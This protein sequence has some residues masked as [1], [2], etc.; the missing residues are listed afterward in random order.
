MTNSPS[1][2]D[3]PLYQE[4]FEKALLQKPEFSIKPMKSTKGDNDYARIM[5]YILER[6]FDNEKNVVAFNKSVR[7]K[8]RQYVQH[9]MT[10]TD[11]SYMHEIAQ[12]EWN[13]TND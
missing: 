5:Q 8:M 12:V 1:I 7:E 10:C 4:L 3:S 9:Y 13:D 6:H 2:Q 11:P